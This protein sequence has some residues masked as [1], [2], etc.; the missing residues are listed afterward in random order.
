MKLLGLRALGILLKNIRPPHQL[1][2]TL[3]DRQFAGRR[4]VAG[5]SRSRTHRPFWPLLIAEFLTGFHLP[6]TARL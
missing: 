4:D 1:E 3:C 2:Q 5:E 6:R